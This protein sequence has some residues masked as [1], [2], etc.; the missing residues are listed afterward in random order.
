MWVVEI[1][2]GRLLVYMLCLMDKMVR[3]YN[4]RQSIK[5]KYVL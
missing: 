4:Y 5:G 3:Y 2:L 1:V